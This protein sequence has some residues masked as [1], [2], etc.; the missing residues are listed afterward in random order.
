M[1]HQNSD[2]FEGELYPFEIPAIKYSAYSIK[3]VNYHKLRCIRESEG[4]I[5]N[6]RELELR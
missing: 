5:G 3:H 4:E 2:G 6:S 1:P